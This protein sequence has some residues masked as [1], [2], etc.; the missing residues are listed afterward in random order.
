MNINGEKE[1]SASREVVWRALN[2][3]A[4]LQRCIPGCKTL[5]QV[6]PTE[7]AATVSLAIGPVKANFSGKVRLQDLNPPE[8]YRIEGEGQGGIAGFAK[9][10]AN[11]RLLET[12]R[13][14]RLE[15]SANSA[16]GGK[17]AQLGS[18]LIESTARKLSDQFFTKFVA[19]VEEANQASA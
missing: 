17:I 6:S 11:V 15:Y 9:G 18:R 1:M 19:I 16:V 8:S 4:V 2:D 13:G 3:P 5:E 10:S 12:E 14:T 7:L